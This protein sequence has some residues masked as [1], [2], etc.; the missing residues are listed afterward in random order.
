MT[1][2]QINQDL[3]R[4]S[5]STTQPRHGYQIGRAG[6]LGLV[7]LLTSACSNVA[8]TPSYRACERDAD[9]YPHERCSTEAQGRCVSTQVPS[10]RSFAFAGFSRQKT[11][12][13]EQAIPWEFKGCE[14]DA[15]DPETGVARIDLSRKLLPIRLDKLT[16]DQPIEGL[17]AASCPPH[18]FCDATKGQCAFARQGRWQLQRSSRIGLA[19]L[20]LSLG[21]EHQS[22]KPG[23]QAPFF[24]LRWPCADTP[25]WLHESEQSLGFE[26][27]TPKQSP[28]DRSLALS[29]IPCKSGAADKTSR[30][31]FDLSQQVRR[32]HPVEVLPIHAIKSDTNGHFDL[33]LSWHHLPSPLRRARTRDGILARS[34]SCTHDQDCKAGPNA[35]GYCDRQGRCRLK[36]NLQRAATLSDLDTYPQRTLLHLDE[37][38]AVDAPL[39]ARVDGAPEAKIASMEVPVKLGED[40][41]IRLCVTDWTPTSDIA[42]LHLDSPDG[43]IDWSS[44]S[45]RPLLAGIM[46]CRAQDLSATSTPQ[47]CESN[48]RPQ[49]TLLATLSDRGRA[50]FEDHGC[51]LPLPRDHALS[52]ELP[53]RCDVH[54]HCHVEQR[55]SELAG[56]C[57]DLA[58]TLQRPAGSLF[59]SVQQTFASAICK[60]EPKSSLVV[61]D[62]WEPRPLLRGRVHSR[63]DPKTPLR[64]RVM[65]ERLQDGSKDPLGP[66]FFAQDVVPEG[67]RRGQ[68]ALPVEP[69]RYVITAIAHDPIKEGL[70]P[71][72]LVDLRD[73][74]PSVD[75][76]STQLELHPGPLVQI[77]V[78][79]P[80]GGQRVS[81]RPIDTGS[82]VDDPQIPDLNDPLTCFPSDRACLIRTL[83]IPEGGVGQ[84][85]PTD[86]RSVLRWATRPGGQHECPTP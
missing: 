22:P 38:A 43:P 20:T 72:Q 83:S 51:S 17:C 64:V 16:F 19:P 37:Q 66:F 68:F 44:F 50:H 73:S 41:S 40:S 10:R 15:F 24:S 71:F 69:G 78:K 9:C 36:L 39:I 77:Q 28:S 8:K 2:R 54:G 58:L 27:G 62:P 21:R 32:S 13:G 79:A 11:E 23:G 7:A 81:A 53:I 29:G 85:I 35:Q 49:V 86:Y 45:S 56:P 82:W 67:P 61:P 33:T 34:L 30:Y 70:A 55:Q 84:E 80:P 12:H 74:A 57:Y 31:L 59:R 4:Q 60:G 47:R 6:W 52:L 42:K 5:R 48:A 1:R 26:L 46:A 25:T 76:T 75:D 14:L 63:Q 65:A 3:H 18:A